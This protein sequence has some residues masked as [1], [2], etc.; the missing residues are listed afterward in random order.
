M[1]ERICATCAFYNENA[2]V[3]EQMGE[4]RRYAPRPILYDCTRDTKGPHDGADVQWPHVIEEDFCGE[5][6]PK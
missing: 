4:C 2:D 5:F 3:G 1:G 6:H